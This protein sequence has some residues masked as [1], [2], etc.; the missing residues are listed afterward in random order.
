MTGKFERE[1]CTGN[2]FA[3]FPVPPLE[4]GKPQEKL[5]GAKAK[6][7]F[8]IWMEI[9]FE[10]GAGKYT[11]VSISESSF[12]KDILIVRKLWISKL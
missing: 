9:H 3:H 1:S 7:V 10:I 11:E 12:R 6:D 8:E 5:S 2:H 4:R